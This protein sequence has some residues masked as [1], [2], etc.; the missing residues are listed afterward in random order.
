MLNL[1]IRRLGDSRDH[2]FLQRV[3]RSAGSFRACERHSA[4]ADEPGLCLPRQGRAVRPVRAHYQA[5]HEQ[6]IAIRRFGHL[7]RRT[8]HRFSAPAELL[9]AGSA[10]WCLASVLSETGD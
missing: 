8:G 3:Q 5:D 2:L 1:A 4:D 10:N 9:I 7:S 6:Q